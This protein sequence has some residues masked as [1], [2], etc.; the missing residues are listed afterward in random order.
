MHEKRWLYHDKNEP[1]IFE[2]GEVEK[3]LKEGW[4][5]WPWEVEEDKEEDKEEKKEKRAYKK[6]DSSICS[7]E[8]IDFPVESKTKE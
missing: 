5:F 4:K 7:I 6:K 8:E 2:A 3:S 1:K